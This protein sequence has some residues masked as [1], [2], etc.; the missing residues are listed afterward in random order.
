[1]LPPN[2]PLSDW[3]PNLPFYDPAQ[4]AD[5]EP[6]RPGAT[7]GRALPSD[8]YRGNDRLR[9]LGLDVYP[10]S[11]GQVMGAVAEES[12][13][14]NPT[15]SLL[16]E[17]EREVRN[18]M[19]RQLLTAAEANEKYGISMELK[20]DRD[21]PERTASDFHDLK[22]AE[23]LRRSIMARGCGGFLERAASFWR[24]RNTR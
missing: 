20:F 1:M 23:L 16:R 14:R 13:V 4:R 11:F 7:G 2:W 22:R 10:T 19:V 6:W 21:T 9:S 3:P 24:C 8:E 18:E 15:P 5:P 12:W 17:G